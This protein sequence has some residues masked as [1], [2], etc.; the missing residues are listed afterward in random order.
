MRTFYLWFQ[1]K[2]FQKKRHN[3][4]PSPL[5]SNVN[6][7]KVEEIKENDL[8]DQDKQK[9]NYAQSA[10]KM[11]CAKFIYEHKLIN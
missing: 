11:L 6:S 4:T 5:L 9:S 10:G 7:E 2:K 8:S 1:L 3:E